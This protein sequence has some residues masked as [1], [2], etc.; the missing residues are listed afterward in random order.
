MK[1]HV[2]RYTPRTGSRTARLLDHALAQLEVTPTVTDLGASQP[3]LFDT[4][5]VDAYVARNYGG[6]ELSAQ[7]AAAIKP[8]MP[9]STSCARPIASF[10]PRRCTTSV[11]RRR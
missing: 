1:L 8:W 7:A 3:P 2:V 6:A 9:T 10:L 5:R 4:T 11:C